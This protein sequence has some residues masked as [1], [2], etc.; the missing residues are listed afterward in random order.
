[1]FSIPRLAIV[2]GLVIYTEGPL[3]MNV[4]QEQLSEMFRPFR[5]LLIKIRDLLRTLSDNELHQLER[6]L[7]TNEDI[8]NTTS[9]DDGGGE[10]ANL[11]AVGGGDCD[12]GDVFMDAHDNYPARKQSIDSGN[13]LVSSSCSKKLESTGESNR[14]NHHNRARSEE[15]AKSDQTNCIEQLVNS[16]ITV[17]SNGIRTERGVN[18]NN[19]DDSEDGEEEEDR[20]EGTLS[21]EEQIVGNGDGALD[22]MND[23]ASGYLIPNTNLGYLLQPPTDRPLTDSFIS[24]DDDNGLDCGPVPPAQTKPPEDTISTTS[25]VSSRSSSTTNTSSCA[26]DDSITKSHTMSSSSSSSS[27]TTSLAS[28]PRSLGEKELMRKYH[29]SRRISPGEKEDSGIGTTAP[30]TSNDRTPET[31]VATTTTTTTITS[32]ASSGDGDH[33]QQEQQQSTAAMTRR[34]NSNWENLERDHSYAVTPATAT[35]A[36]DEARIDGSGRPATASR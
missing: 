33:H 16:T 23:C 4:P 36:T 14:C 29:M 32:T 27:S 20:S 10:N 15:E 19:N 9:I 22:V 13:I 25:S 12:D 24:T 17:D 28:P 21:S 34:Y 18:D 7:C 26:S 6:L 11:S 1:M 35:T 2:V 8:P 3:N 31:E 30:N 5:V